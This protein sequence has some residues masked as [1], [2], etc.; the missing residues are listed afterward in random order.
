VLAVQGIGHQDATPAV[1]Q[2]LLVNA[3]DRVVVG[4]LWVGATVAGLIAGVVL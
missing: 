2:V 3:P 4:T 1:G